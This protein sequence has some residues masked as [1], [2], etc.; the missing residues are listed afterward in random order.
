MYYLQSRYY[1]P[2]I[3]R[4]LN[5]DAFASTGQGLLGNNMF[6]YCRNNPISRKDVT[7]NWDISVEDNADD[8]NPLND[9]GGAV[10]GAGGGGNN[11]SNAHSWLA[12][13][14]NYGSPSNTQ[15]IVPSNKGFGNHYDPNVGSA[16]NTLV[17]RDYYINNKAPKQSTPGSQL[18][19]YS[20][21]PY[22]G[23]WEHSTSFYDFAGRQAIRI[24]WTNH[25]RLD[26]GSPHVHL[27]N[28]NSMYRDGIHRRFD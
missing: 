23:Q 28:Y 11:T 17:P 27:Y 2:G 8:D 10:H 18:E 12:D 4:F 6:A 3:G 26:H 21:N 20:Y 19:T 5:A 25:G 9:M 13:G 15:N 14:K 24:D 1:D 7:G 16:Q 22:T